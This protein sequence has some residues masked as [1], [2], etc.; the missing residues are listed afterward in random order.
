M[1]RIPRSKQREAKTLIAAFIEERLLNSLGIFDK[2]N[3]DPLLVAAIER[4]VERLYR[5]GVQE[6]GEAE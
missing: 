2:E 4:E 5:A 3:I 6:E 1:M